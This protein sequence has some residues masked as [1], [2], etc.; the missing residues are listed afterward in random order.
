VHALPGAAQ[1]GVK[2]RGEAPGAAALAADEQDRLGLTGSL[3]APDARTTAPPGEPD[4][5]ARS[6]HHGHAERHQS[7]HQPERRGAQVKLGAETVDA[8]A[9]LTC[10]PNAEVWQVHP[11]AMPVIL[12][13]DDLER[14]LTAPA[15][16]ALK[17]QRPLSEGSL[18]IVAQGEPDDPMP[19]I[20]D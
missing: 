9:I 14:W 18:R 16:A 1:R 4:Q 13:H 19:D 6:A 5:H 15:A 2:R 3:I 7:Q 12:R 8:F 10:P 20:G 17:L 11:K